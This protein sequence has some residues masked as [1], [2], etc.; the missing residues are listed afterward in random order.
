MLEDREYVC[1]YLFIY[2]FSVLLMCCVAL[3]CVVLCEVA[4]EVVC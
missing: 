3:C 1:V 4:L 2:F